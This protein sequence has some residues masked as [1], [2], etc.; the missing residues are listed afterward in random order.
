MLLEIGGGIS[1]RSLSE[2]VTFKLRSKNE[3]TNTQSNMPDYLNKCTGST[4]KCVEHK[5]T[6]THQG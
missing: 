4:H 2:E 5:H 1:Q 6:H 3:K